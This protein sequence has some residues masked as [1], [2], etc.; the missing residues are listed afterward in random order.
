MVQIIICET[1]ITP[2]KEHSNIKILQLDPLLYIVMYCH[3]KIS[4]FVKQTMT[5]YFTPFH[6]LLLS[7][8]KL[9]NLCSWI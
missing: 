8:S 7:H 6:S 5:L 3:T 1:E 4:S 9:Y 2:K